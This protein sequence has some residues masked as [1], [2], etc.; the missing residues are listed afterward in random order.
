MKN[1]IIKFLIYGL[2]ITSLNCYSQTQNEYEESSFQGKEEVSNNNPDLELISPKSIGQTIKFG[3]L[4]IMKSDLGKFNWND[5]NTAC[6]KLGK[7]W[8]LPTAKELNSIYLN[9]KFIGGFTKDE[10]W[11]STSEVG[12]DENAYYQSFGNEV[13]RLTSNKVYE[14]NVRA[15]KSINE[16]K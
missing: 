12:F 11:S 7:G 8:R 16:K 10:Y 5:A 3:N 14:Q 6:S 4:E 13:V 2:V 1:R 15:V 9:R